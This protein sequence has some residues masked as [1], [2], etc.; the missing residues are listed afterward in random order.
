MTEPNDLAS[1]QAQELGSGP[2]AWM[3]RNNVAANLL[4]L[5]LIVAGGLGILSAKQ[6]VFPEFDLDQVN[7]TVAYPGA[8]PGEVEQS[9][10]LAVE[11]KV[12][13]IDGVK[14]VDSTAR[15]GS[16]TVAVSLLLDANP[17][18]VL[19]DVKNEVDRVTTFPVEAEEPVVS[20]AKRRSQV[21]S[22]ILS[23]DHELQ[24]LHAIAE[25]ARMRLL[26][27]EDITQVE[28]EGVPALELS[29]EVPRA[30]LERYGLTLDE[31]AREIGSASLELPAG[32][33]ESDSGEIRVRVSDRRST[34]QAISELILRGTRGGGE[35]RLGDI[36]TITDGYE[37]SKQYSLYNGKPAVR[38]TAYRTGDETPTAVA[39]AVRETAEGLRAQLPPE[40]EVSVW[41]DDSEVL[42]DRISL[43]TKNAGMGLLLVLLV[44]ALFLD[45]R[46]AFW[47]SLGI[48][49]SF[50]GAFVVLGGTDLSINMITLFAFI[51]T[52]GMVVDDAIVVGERTH[53]YRQEGH[54]PMAAAILAARDMA[55][56]ITFAILTT[57]AAFMPMLFV[58]GTMGKV[59]EM[60]PMVVIAV[61]IIS[62]IESFFI[63]P[64]HL[65]HTPDARGESSRLPRRGIVGVF[66]KLQDGVASGLATFIAKVYTPVVKAFMRLRYLAMAGA[67][68]VLVLTVAFVASGA[69]PFNFFPQIEGDLVTVQVRLPYGVALART[70]AVG[71][72]LQASLG[73]TIDEFGGEAKVRGVYTR[74]GQSAP[75]AGPGAVEAESGSH[76]IAFEVALVPSGERD[77][78]AE[79]FLDDWRTRTG[80]LHEVESIRFTAASGPGAGDAVAIQVL[81][82][83]EQ[84]LAAVAGEL[85]ETL[86]S[87][88]ELTNIENGYVSGKP[89]LDFR[90]SD[91]AR[92]LGFSAEM[93]AAQLRAAFYGAEAVREQRG[94]NELK[95]M[96]R[97][98][99]DERRTEH[100]LEALMIR[101]PAGEFVPLGRLVD[102][103]R[104]LAPT[105]IEREDGRRKVV[106]SAELAPGVPSPRPVLEALDEGVFDDLRA[107]YPELDIEMV[108]AQREQRETFAALGRG[109]LL[110]LLLIYALLAIPFRSYVQPVIIMMVIPFGFVGAIAGHALMG[111]GL[112]LMSMFGLIALSGVVVNDSLVLI[113]A[114]NKARLADPSLSAFDAVL[115]GGIQR[116]RPILLTSLTTFFGLVPMLAETSMQARFLIPMAISLAFGV[117]AATVVVLLLVPSLYLIVEDAI[118]LVSRRGPEPEPK[119]EP[120]PES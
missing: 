80:E 114:T 73:Q 10:I 93:V 79:Q 83:D 69:V 15:E 104:G 72:Q 23:G 55:G 17:Q 7:V 3:V 101:S 51:V 107:R 20:L 57:I 56:P 39:A 6:E 99:E 68:S 28:L 97:L 14:R 4:M 42:D 74:V 22:L 78:T 25:D 110:A 12:R 115:G 5:V 108:G 30:E 41:Q 102:L 61:L 75:G 85:T 16:G 87:Y 67:L 60:I 52:L 82:A 86:S 119:P 98:P 2:L 84:A 91:E 100:D 105:S 64:A 27:H 31:V 62:L 13:G 92:G 90:L 35:L 58:P 19:A 36:A 103:E 18:E 34:G 11:E 37:D 43:L 45:L 116:F 44:L 53:A 88:A 109:Y 48:P 29:V 24:D 120:E 94:R 38:V 40:V 118:A 71:E 46:L 32:A 106:V 81:S 21:V 66:G 59:F 65:A 9:I 96:T 47:V 117:L 26:Q 54:A 33:L 77:F 8:S 76:L 1:G 50:M 49:I 70:E 112:S 63:L 113:D 111:Y 89:Q 95:I